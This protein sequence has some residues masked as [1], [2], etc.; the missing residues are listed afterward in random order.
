MPRPRR[1]RAYPGSSAWG[2]GIGRA[3]R[4]AYIWQVKGAIEPRYCARPAAAGARR[5][6]VVYL[7]EGRH[8]RHP[9][10]ER[11]EENQVDEQ[12]GKGVV[13]DRFWKALGGVRPFAEAAQRRIDLV[14]R[15]RDLESPRRSWNHDRC[16]GQT[17]FDYID[18]VTGTVYA[19]CKAGCYCDG[20]NVALS[21]E[22]L[23]DPGFEARVQKAIAAAEAVVAVERAAEEARQADREARARAVREREE[24]AQ[25]VRLRSQMGGIDLS[26]QSK[27][28]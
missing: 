9:T 4:T 23:F 13:P 2:R 6:A 5:R 10:T 15:L 17:T 8:A 25:A 3:R 22:D 16:L 7:S 27:A 14:V 20:E 18:T 1:D 21:P 24:Q 19:S 11:T 26:H 12:T 28:E